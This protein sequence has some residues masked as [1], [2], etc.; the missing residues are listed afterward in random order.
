MKNKKKAFTLTELLVVVIVIGVLSAAVLPKFSKV[1]ETRKTTEAEELM[2]SIR[3]EQEKR[4]ALDKPYLTDLSQM[5]DIVKTASTKNYQIN[6]QNK[7]INAASKGNYSYTLQMPS[8]ADGRICCDGDDCAK[9]NKNYPSCQGFTYEPSPDSCAGTINTPEPEEPSECMEGEVRG[10]QSCN[11]CGTQTTQ[12]CIGGKWVENLG[13]CSKKQ[14]ECSQTCKSSYCYPYGNNQKWAYHPSSWYKDRTW[15]NDT[16]ECCDSNPA[17]P[18][19][20]A[21]GQKKIADFYQPGSREKE[22]CCATP[23]PETCPKG[24]QRTNTTYEEYGSCCGS[25]CRDVCGGSGYS[26]PN[27]NDKLNQEAKNNGTNRKYHWEAAWKAD[28]W[29]HSGDPSVCY[30]CPAELRG[31]AA[32]NGWY[33]YKDTS[34]NVISVGVDTATCS[35]AEGCPAG[36]VAKSGNKYICEKTNNFVPEEHT[37]KGAII[38][39]TGQISVAESKLVWFDGGTA[40]MNGRCWTWSGGNSVG[41]VALTST[42]CSSFGGPAAFCNQQC[43]NRVSCDAVCLADDTQDDFASI[44]SKQHTLYLESGSNKAQTVPDSCC[45][46][47]S[48][49]GSLATSYTSGCKQ[50]SAKQIVSVH[51]FKCVVAK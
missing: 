7:G 23:C 36:Y 29:F 48:T 18:E 50:P 44:T 46:K 31:S 11:G 8:Y 3:T 4:C 26:C 15:V 33:D 14:E 49:P 38:Y 47:T 35:V 32:A 51:L 45:N 16:T 42:R 13:E 43:A 22:E 5:N 21:A 24:E 37:Y 34:G 28:P 9:L 1:I 25:P 19:T 30:R 27:I 20:C 17:C 39:G 41:S 12:K 6:L 10:S 2:A 40:A